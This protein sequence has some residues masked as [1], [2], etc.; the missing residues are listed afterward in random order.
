[1]RF[2]ERLR[3]PRAA[4]RH[5]WWHSGL[6][7]SELNRHS[8][9]GIAVLAYH[10][11]RPRNVPAAQLPFSPLHID[12]D[13]FAEHCAF[14]REHCTVIDAALYRDILSGAA[15]PR[16]AV[17][18]TFDDGYRNCVTHALPS[19][20]RYGL[21]AVFFVCS[22]PS[23]HRQLHW[24]DVLARTNGEDAVAHLRERSYDA[25][26]RAVQRLE[27]N[28]RPDDPASVMSAAE[29]AALA[30]VP[31]MTIGCHTTWHP[32]LSAA[33]Y[34]VQLRELTSCVEHLRNWTGQ[35]IDFVA[36][37][38]GRASDYNRDTLRAARECGLVHGFTTE[39]A[40]AGPEYP[41]L[42][43]PRRTMVQGLTVAELAH[44]LTR[45]WQ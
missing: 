16:R 7:A 29:V 23:G 13:L 6:G 36:Y 38:V 14:Y 42:E 28:P 39:E 34:D 24:Y 3:H 37:P 4:L 19:L 1:M 10:G 30:R 22:G 21:P 41:P 18:L 25:W 43:Q 44:R 20:Q 35:P 40:F 27:R 32:R 26:E 33:P 2:V 8:F 17:L 11:I 12:E 31:G 9:S 5:S 15:A 45:V